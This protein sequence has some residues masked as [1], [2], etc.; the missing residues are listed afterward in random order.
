MAVV[1]ILLFVGEA[2]ITGNGVLPLTGDTK[3]MGPAEKGV[4]G[5]ELNAL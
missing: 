2:G 4:F 5:G 3:D 1:I